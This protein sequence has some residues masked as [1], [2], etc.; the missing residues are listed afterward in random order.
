VAGLSCLLVIGAAAT[1]SPVILDSEN[2]IVVTLSDG[3][4]V[5]LYGEA[6]P[7]SLAAPAVQPSPPSGRETSGRPPLRR[8]AD[9][10]KSNKFYYLPV[11]LRLGKR[12]DG[13]PE[14][15]F[16]KYTTE[17]SVAQGGLA[18][19]LMH[20]LME[21]GLTSRQEQELREKLKA[22]YGNAQ[23]MGT[24]PLEEVGE[25][26]FQ[27]TS[28]TVSDKG[29]T[30][31]VVTSGKAP[32]LPGDKAAAAARLTPEGAQLLAATFEKARSITDLSITLNYNF[33]TLMPA[34]RG[35]FVA[36]WSKLLKEHDTLT[37]E[38]AK[39]RNQS[40]DIH[41]VIPF[42]CWTTDSSTYTYSYEEAKNQFRFLEEK[43]VF[44]FRFDE[45][46]ADERT[47]KIREA[48]FQLVLN[49]MGQPAKEQP[50]PPPKEELQ[51]PG[52]PDD[53]ER[54]HYKKEAQKYVQE[55]RDETLFMDLRLAVRGPVHLTGNLASW[56]DGV[57]DN[58]KCVAAV[59]LNDPFFQHRDI[60]F[61]LDLDAKEMFDEA[62]NYV[63]VNV[64]KRRSSG[65][66]FEDHVTIDAKYLKEHGINASVTYARGEDRNPDVYEYQT[67]WS[68]KGGQVYP[69]SPRWERGSWEGVTLAPPVVPRTIEVEGDLGAM[70]ASDI[71]RVTV[72]IHYPKFGEEVEE[73]IHLSAAGSEP[74]VKKKIFTDRDARGY[75]YRLVV[76]HKTEGKLVLPWSAKV[77]DDYVYATIPEDLLREGSPLKEQAKTA[78]K[79]PG[80]SAREKVLD[81][82][83]EVL[84][85]KPSP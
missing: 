21:W 78:G 38:Y 46:L 37:M 79:A 75:A 45:T 82:F 52:I 84:G 54:Y 27:I 43:G 70:K 31:V 1:A 73:N 85:G 72:Q 17:K 56:Y 51:A 67:Q 36:R 50:P 5:T 18:G 24:V 16:L 8:T 7:I 28:A 71:T 76:N 81:S 4:H 6:V 60:N 55:G 2:L 74:L 33:Q 83:K 64:R 30:P 80:D 11:N 29:L 65:Y 57:R 3:T 58:P 42:L 14:F 20:F 44:V 15:L 48:F 12:P 23:L 61:I 53:A 41:C 34:A 9:E 13:T 39:T 47:A 19:G 77:G 35:V 69:P 59:N 25:G 68:L 66:P 63:T 40:T 62:V 22:Q 26:S 32:L 49:R 10:P